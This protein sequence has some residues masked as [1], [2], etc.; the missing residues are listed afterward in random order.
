MTKLYGNP[1]NFR[2]KKVL[3]SAKL[4]NKNV[5]VVSEAPPAKQFPLGLVIQNT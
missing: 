1:D 2:V 3:I 5:N 4:A